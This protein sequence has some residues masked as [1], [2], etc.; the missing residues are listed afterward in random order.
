M[1]V[2]A[3]L[4]VIYMTYCDNIKNQHTNNTSME[5]PDSVPMIHLSTS[6]PTIPLDL[7]EEIKDKGYCGD[8]ICNPKNNEN[9]Q[10]C[11]KDCGCNENFV[12]MGDVCTIK[13]FNHSLY[14]NEVFNYSIEIP[15]GWLGTKYIDAVVFRGE[16]GTDE[17]STTIAINMIPECNK[18]FRSILNDLAY[19]RPLENILYSNTTLSNQHA[20]ESI[21]AQSYMN[22][23]LKQ[24]NI[25]TCYK[26]YIYILSYTSVVEHY[27]L[28]INEFNHSKN[29]FK[30]TED[31]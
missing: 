7:Q 20:E 19:M 10:T 5:N 21:V 30:F 25:V 27:N 12:C 3:M 11:C 9:I 28:S 17:W 22:A 4:I 24:N 14:I 16:E 2:I 29:S 26:N 31:V 6:I 1:T 23:N 13:Y 15:F 18:S 8:D